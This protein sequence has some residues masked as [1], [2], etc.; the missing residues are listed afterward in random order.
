MLHYG[1]RDVS[2]LLYIKWAIC[3]SSEISGIVFAF[4]KLELRSQ[5]F[6]VKELFFCSGVEK[7]FVQSEDSPTIYSY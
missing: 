6:L 4:A 5:T 7:M 3:N 2:T 1:R